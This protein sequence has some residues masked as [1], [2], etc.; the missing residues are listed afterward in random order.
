MILSEGGSH[1][2]IDGQERAKSLRGGFQARRIIHCTKDN[3]DTIMICRQTDGQTDRRTECSSLLL[4]IVDD[5]HNISHAPERQ[6]LANRPSNYASGRVSEPSKHL[7][8][9]TFPFKA[10]QKYNP[11]IGSETWVVNNG[12]WLADDGEFETS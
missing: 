11:H 2:S 10:R 9:M 6:A 12:I 7:P 1:D 3:G 8:T 5:T 4:P